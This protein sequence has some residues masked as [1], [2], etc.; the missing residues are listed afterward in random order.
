M[1]R[2]QKPKSFAGRARPGLNQPFHPERWARWLE[3]CRSTLELSKPQFVR[4]IQEAA[5]PLV[6][7]PSRGR[8]WAVTEVYP[9]TARGSTRRGWQAYWIGEAI[10]E[11]QKE[12][13][14]YWLWTSGLESLSF[15]GYFG[16]LIAVIGLTVGE[17]AL[18][19]DVLED[20]LTVANPASACIIEVPGIEGRATTNGAY[21]EMLDEWDFCFRLRDTTPF[22]ASLS[23]WMR[24]SRQLMLP[25][26]FDA[27]RA[28]VSNGDEVHALELLRSA[29]V[30]RSIE[31]FGNAPPESTWLR[32][33]GLALQSNRAWGI[34]DFHSVH[35]L[36]QAPY[37][38]SPRQHLRIFA[39]F[40]L[41]ERED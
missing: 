37:R 7:L 20:A 15:G 19:E 11:I 6:P 30:I 9:K 38:P 21:E 14:Y 13:L 18:T 17:E 8:N 31:R 12:R 24:S 10:R 2:E 36:G 26:A 4:T 29:V 27:A 40:K 1:A 33:P 39:E 34:D 35:V 3:R 25:W 16:D 32:G 23:R 41:P 22:S 28:C 5:A